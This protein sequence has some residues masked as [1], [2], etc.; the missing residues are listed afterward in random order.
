MPDP[1]TPPVEDPERILYAEEQIQKAYFRWYDGIYR[2]DPE[3]L[4]GAVTGPISLERGIA[5]MEWM[6][7]TAPPTLEGVEVNVLDT[8]CRPSRLSGGGLRYG[9]QFLSGDGPDRRD[10][11]HV[12]SP[13]IWVA[14]EYL[15]RVAHHLWRLVGKLLL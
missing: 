14:S 13:T 2:K 1:L 3:I 5:A 7:F 4:W 15:I 12:V 9:P 10:N 8:V 6:E 11:S